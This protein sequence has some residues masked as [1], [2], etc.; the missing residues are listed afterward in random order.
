MAI[1]AQDQKRLLIV[2]LRED[3]SG[4][5]Y[6][7]EVRRL[8]VDGDKEVAPPQILRVAATKE[9]ADKIL[10]V[11]IASLN[12]EHLALNVQLQDERD[13]ADAALK[14]KDDT[15]VASLRALNVAHASELKAKDDELATALKSKDAAIEAEK[16]E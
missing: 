4:S 14:A 16:P 3:G 2:T 7:F 6:Q 5:D 10:G 8:L 9:E 13:A 15:H 11:G 12:A 1:E